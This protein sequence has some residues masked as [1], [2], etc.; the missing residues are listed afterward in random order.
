M[1][2]FVFK[3]EF[4][5]RPK[6]ENTGKNNGEIEFSKSGILSNVND[7]FNI[8]YG[9]ISKSLGDNIFSWTNLSKNSEYTK[10]II[11]WIN[12]YESKNPTDDSYLKIEYTGTINSADTENIFSF[13]V[14]YTNI[15]SLDKRLYYIGTIS[16]GQIFCH[17][18]KNYA[19]GNII[20]IRQDLFKKYS[21]TT[22]ISTNNKKYKLFGS[23]DKND[24][25][26]RDYIIEF[27]NQE[28]IKNAQKYIEDN[29]I[30]AK[31]Y[32]NENKWRDLND[33][34][35]NKYYNFKSK[36]LDKNGIHKNPSEFIGNEYF[37]FNISPNNQ[38]NSSSL[39]LVY[40][41]NIISEVKKK[42]PNINSKKVMRIKFKPNL[43]KGHGWADIID[44][45]QP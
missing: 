10:N 28:Q 35:Y 37:K 15:V 36:G 34:K 38:K 5:I 40:R 16:Y 25:L 23:Y 22:N 30:S 42:F 27:V 24:N 1:N 9:I 6:I 14:F 20:L 31:I 19:I 3:I 33:D 29:K 43:N 2:N 8:K 21:Q 41:K 44:V 26:T 18:I 45:K 7:L 32:F 13:H 39:N 11:E 17:N 12:N 4:N